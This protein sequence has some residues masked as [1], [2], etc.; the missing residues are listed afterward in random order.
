MQRQQT[1]DPCSRIGSALQ[2]CRPVC[3]WRTDPT[4]LST[5]W[6]SNSIETVFCFLPI[7][8]ANR[9]GRPRPVFSGA[10]ASSDP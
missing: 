6:D 4:Q 3:A 5:G 9:I 1:L 8:G 7:R 2:W 10:S